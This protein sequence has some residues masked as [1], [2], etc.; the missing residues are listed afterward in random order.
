MAAAR[1][2]LWPGQ[3]STLLPREARAALRAAYEVQP[4]LPLGES[5]ARTGAIEM[6]SIRIRVLYPQFFREDTLIKP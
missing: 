5:V 6:E 4:G 3:V 1:K 2:L